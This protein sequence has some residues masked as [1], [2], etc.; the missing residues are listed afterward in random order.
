MRRVKNVEYN[1]W[2]D[3]DWGDDDWGSWGTGDWSQAKKAAPKV[4]AKAEVKKPKQQAKAK[5]K[6]TRPEKVPEEEKK[7]PEQ[8][9][10]GDGVETTCLVIT[11]HVDAGK[12]TLMGHL[13]YQMGHVTAR[14]MHKMEKE[15][16]Q[17]GK[18]DFKFA[19]VLDEGN[20]ERE[21]GVTIDICIKHFTTPKGRPLTI[22]DA[23]GHRDFVPNMV[24]GACLADV[25]VL[26]VDVKDFESGF[27]RGGQTKEHLQLVRSLGA[28]QLVVCINKMDAV[29][30]AEQRY[31]TVM[32]QLKPYIS[33]LGFKD[34]KVCFVPISGFN[35]DNLTTAKE[36][37]W[38]SGSLIDT[39][40]A[41]ASPDRHKGDLRIPVSDSY[42]SGSNM[43]LS[44][45]V[46]SGEVSVGQKI[47]ILPANEQ[48]AVKSLIAREV[49]C[50]KA[51]P[52]VYLDS[53]VLPLEP[54]FVCPGSVVCINP[55]P[56]V[57][58]FKAR[59]CV[60]ESPLPMVKGQQ[61]TLHCSSQQEACTLGVIE[62]SSKGGRKFKCL[63]KGNIAIVTLKAHR[64]IYAE[65]GR[66]SLGRVVL[67]DKGVTIAAGLVL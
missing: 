45:K 41:L 22:V 25:A 67:R 56:L 24:L 35:G 64:A 48:V 47:T 55:V 57:S 14:E 8:V 39:L 19:W 11:G 46:E 58:E 32:D 10:E 4:A 6:E 38:H 20:D 60:M 50:R 28:G 5:A 26:V 1:D 65:A 34:D 61:Y 15:S 21:R 53:L 17:I 54:Q 18:G 59:I 23:P 44:G 36:L 30:W 13:L 43:V 42:K 3:G 9:A 62:P 63:V 33:S 7:E 40:D 66:T 52:G 37:T 16:S 2:D 49:P 27:A 31:I 29:D 51:G 12:S